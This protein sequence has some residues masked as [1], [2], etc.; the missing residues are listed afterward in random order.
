[1]EVFLTKCL[2]F[3]LIY[4]YIFIVFSIFEIFFKKYKEIKLFNQN[5]AVD[6]AYGFI[7]NIIN[8]FVI[9]Y[10]LDAL[11]QNFLK[12]IIGERP[13]YEVI[14]SWPFLVKLLLAL[15][16]IDFFQY[17][18]HRFTH[19]FMWKFHVAHHSSK[20]L[21]W[22]SHFRFHPVEHILNGVMFYIYS[23]ILGFDLLEAYY[24]SFLVILNNMYLHTNLNIKYPAP[25]KYIL[26]SPNYHKWHHGNTKAEIDKNFADIFVFL[27]IIFGT[28]YVPKDRDFPDG[29][30][31]LGMKDEDKFSKSFIRQI[32]YPISSQ[33]KK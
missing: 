28:F 31:V 30:G 23:Y 4:A 29:Y 6:F 25:L 3:I 14:G 1:M 11:T 21:R 12:P 32:I 20:E 19:K 26:V 13:L 22:S 27:D 5:A 9:I 16:L 33:I 15:F 17:W 10:L 8:S 7:N 2:Y 24:M 18:R